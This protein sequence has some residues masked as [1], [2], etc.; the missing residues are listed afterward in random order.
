LSEAVIL[1][2]AK[3]L[4]EDIGYRIVGTVE[5]AKGDEWMLAKAEELKSEC[6]RVVGQNSGRKL[7]CE[8]FHQRG[9]GSFK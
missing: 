8:V 3:Y 1:G 4:T 5:N 7:Q 6:E 2:H 9:N